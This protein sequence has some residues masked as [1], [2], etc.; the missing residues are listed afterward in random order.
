MNK[1]GRVRLA[2]ISESDAG[3]MGRRTCPGVRHGG[4]S[5]SLP[6]HTAEITKQA[7]SRAVRP[8]PTGR[9]AEAQSRAFREAPCSPRPSSLE[10]FFRPR[11]VPHPLAL[12]GFLRETKK[13]DD[14]A[15]DS[16]SPR[17]APNDTVASEPLPSHHSQNTP[18]HP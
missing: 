7:G 4:P 6:T 12:P 5:R 9:A 10:Y 14:V 2:S 8:V 15:S 1:L 13:M 11:Y 18:P 16:R 3:R 17:R